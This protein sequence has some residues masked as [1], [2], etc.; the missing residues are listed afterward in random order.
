MLGLP[1]SPQRRTDLESAYDRYLIDYGVQEDA[2]SRIQMLLFARCCSRHSRAERAHGYRSCQPS[3]ALLPSKHGLRPFG[4]TVCWKHLK[5]CRISSVMGNKRTRS[6]IQQAHLIGLLPGIQLLWLRHDNR[7]GLCRRPGGWHM[8]HRV[9]IPAG[10][11]KA[12]GTAIYAELMRRT[13]N[14]RLETVTSFT[15][16]TQ[17]REKVDFLVGDALASEP[18]ALYR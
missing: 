10:Y 4:L 8:Q 1:V 11:R 3:R 15:A 2:G 5:V 18:Y 6:F 12:F 14:G 7:R 16:P 9:L 13:A 17:A